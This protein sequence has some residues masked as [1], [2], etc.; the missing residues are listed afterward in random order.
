MRRSLLKVPA[1]GCIGCLFTLVL[2]AALP[3]NADT[4]VIVNPGFETGSLSPWLNGRDFCTFP[5]QA[6]MV[7]TTDPHS[8]SYDAMD[9]GNIELIQYIVP[10][11]TDLITD[12]SLWERHPDGGTLPVDA[13]FYYSD[14]TVQEIGGQK[15]TTD[16]NWTFFDWTSYLEP[17][18]TLTAF[19]TF[20]FNGGLPG[21]SQITFVDDVK[22]LTSSTTPEPGTLVLLGSGLLG[23]V[24]VIRRKLLL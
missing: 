9:V 12:V 18:K 3:G 14:G 21:D 16:A 5:C 19:S 4:N 6:W 20:G 10:T 17:G 22:I 1:A 23:V 13:I 24:C 2:L 15:F 8:G 7:S 11:L